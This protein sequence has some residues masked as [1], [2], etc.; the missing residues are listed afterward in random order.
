[1]R[2]IGG[3]FNEKISQNNMR[4]TCNGNAFGRCGLRPETGNT[5]INAWRF[6]DSRAADSR[7][8]DS[9]AAHSR[10]AAY[11]GKGYT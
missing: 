11:E 9:R 8:A 4:H 7:A 6:A 10:A 1:M 5:V 2:V 3:K